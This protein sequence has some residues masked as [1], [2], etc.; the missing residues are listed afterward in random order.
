MTTTA[1]RTAAPAASI[2]EAAI[3]L[4]AHNVPYNVA[5]A[6]CNAVF[7]SP[8][9]QLFATVVLAVPKDP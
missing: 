7:K 8:R 9:E 4:V 3:V 6:V 5:I 1:R 2:V